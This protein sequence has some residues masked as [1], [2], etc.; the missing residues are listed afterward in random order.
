MDDWVQEF[1]ESWNSSA[2][3]DEFLSR[4]PQFTNRRTVISMAS[5]L[6]RMGFELKKF[7]RNQTA[8]QTNQERYILAERLHR[9][10]NVTYQE[11][12][13]LMGVTKQAAHAG[14][15]KVREG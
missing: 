2:S 9:E 12:A 10:K 8:E 14:I 5:N 15:K 13:D 11:I 6:R 4:N 7:H 1:I 3:V